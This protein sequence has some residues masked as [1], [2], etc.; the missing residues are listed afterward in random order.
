[1]AVAELIQSTTISGLYLVINWYREERSRTSSL[2]SSMTSSRNF[3]RLLWSL[4][5]SSR[6]RS[7]NSFRT[8]ILPHYGTK[9]FLLTF[10]YSRRIVSHASFASDSLSEVRMI[11]FGFSSI[12]LRQIA[13]PTS[14]QPPRTR[15]D[16]FEMTI[17]TLCLR[18]RNKYVRK[19][20][21]SGILCVKIL[22]FGWN[23]NHCFLYWLNNS[24][25]IFKSP[26]HDKIFP[27]H[28]QWFHFLEL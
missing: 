24:W 17:A 10:G 7:L 9:K 21:A 20:F 22:R 14:P 8:K 28:L 19:M 23:S 2:S 27:S 26:Q 18:F 15:T 13:E 4:R 5:I 11:C 1:M 25:N 12:N 6:V 16:L 3:V